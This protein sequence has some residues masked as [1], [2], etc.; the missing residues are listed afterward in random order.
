MTEF[1]SGAILRKED[2]RDIILGKVQAQVELPESYIPDMSWFKR[3]YQGDLPCCGAFAT[4]HLKQIQEHY[5]ESSDKKELSPVYLWKRTKLIDGYRPEDGTCSYAIHKTLQKFGSAEYGL[6]NENLNQTLAQYT[7]ATP[8]TPVID[9]DASIR[10]AEAYGFETL[11]T[12]EQIKQAIYKN[13]AVTLLLRGDGGFW[14]NTEPTFNSIRWG[15]FVCAYS[16]DS[17]GIWIIDSAESEEKFG[18]KH[19]DK[20][21]FPTMFCYEMSTSIDCSNKLLKNLTSQIKLLREVAN[22]YAKL[23]DLNKIQNA[24]NI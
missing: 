5:D 22:L 10:R 2:K 18:Y 12:F 1:K 20:K 8:I 4:S 19:I 24:K 9:E 17:T 6:L 15:H 23:K 21:Y 7:D 3:H 11:P 14:R 16:W 13:K